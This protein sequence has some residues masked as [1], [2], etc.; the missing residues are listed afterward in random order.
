MTEEHKYRTVNEEEENDTEKKGLF[1]PL[2]SVDTSVRHKGVPMTQLFGHTISE[3]RRD[4]LVALLMAICAATMNAAVYVLVIMD[5]LS[6]DVLYLM[7]I[8]LLSA[9]L[10]GMTSSQTSFGIMSAL[11][12]TVLSV[13]M[14]VLF[15]VSPA[16]FLP[17]VGFTDM[18]LLSMSSSM[19][20]FLL[21]FL[22]SFIGVF[23]GLLLREFF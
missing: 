6:S 1:R 19:T 3:R 12:S 21:I 22:G 13:A 5:I 17:S 23:I 16:I 9:L 2:P 8:P 10:I 14:I 11:L 15:M 7:G 18:F 20:Y 4:I